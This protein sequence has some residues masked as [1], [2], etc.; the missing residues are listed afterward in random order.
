MIQCRKGGDFM[1][2]IAICDDDVET[3]ERTYQMILDYT[4]EQNETEFYVRQFNSSYDLLECIS[5][6]V[7]FDIYLLDIIMP[8]INGIV[9][10]QKIRINDK[11]AII[12]YVTTSMDFAVKAYQVGAFDYLIKPVEQELI[13]TVMQ[14]AINKIDVEKSQSLMVKT[15]DGITAVLYHLIMIAEHMDRVVKFNLSDGSIVTSVTLRE[16]FETLIEPLMQDKRFIHPHT[17]YVINMQFVRA[18]T[19][20]DFVMVDNRLVP[21]SRNRYTEVRNEYLDFLQS[22][23][24]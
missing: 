14:K 11:T 16:P 21:I 5:S 22:G 17:S 15:K 18:I 23:R 1:L 4:K 3:L 12:I 19:N 10:G 6:D 20:R 13:F 2:K 8:V 24:E 7:N 9:V